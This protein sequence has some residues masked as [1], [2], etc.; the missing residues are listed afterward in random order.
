MKFNPTNKSDSI[1]AQIDFLLWGDSTTFNT[2]YSLI[3]RTR[4]TNLSYDEIVPFLF[5]ADPNLMW[6]DTNNADFPL[7]TIDLV[8]NRSHYTFPDGS[9]VINRIRIKDQNG[10]YKTLTPKLRRELS[11]EELKATG[12]PDKYY[13]IDNAIFPVPVPSY[14]ATAGVELEFQRGANHF[15]STDTDKS[16]GFAS[17]FHEFLPVGAAYRYAIANGLKEKAAFLMNEMNRIKTGILEHYQRRSPDE[18]P[19]F[20]L[21]RTYPQAGL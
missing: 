10:E 15:A 6:D 21:K 11:D 1:V 20:R 2:A 8:A 18:R 5:R 14:G 4:N 7:A 3:D 12:E 13:K 16:P 9:L 17:Q 19:K